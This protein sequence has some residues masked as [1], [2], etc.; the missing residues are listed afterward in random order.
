M[1]KVNVIANRVNHIS[2]N[3][4]EDYIGVDRGALLCMQQ[5]IPMRLAI[6]D[7]DSI[8]EESLKQLQQYCEVH[9]LPTQKNEVDSECAIRY[10]SE[11]Y[12]EIDVY[13]VSGGRLDHF[14]ILMQFMKKQEIAFRI[15]DEQNYIQVLKAGTHTIR[16]LGKYVSFFPLEPLQLTLEGFMYPLHKQSV[17]V[18]DLY[19]SSN[20]IVDEQAS[21]IVSGSIMMIQSREQNET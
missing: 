9:I 18:F 21:V 10:A 12:D 19:L 4:G 3:E 7:F 5:N 11:F 13:G 20:E 8:S 14:M 6:G 17:D 2:Y 1:S 15:V 16:K